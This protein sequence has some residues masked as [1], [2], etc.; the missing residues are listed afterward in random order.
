M[1]EVYR[2]WEGFLEIVSILKALIAADREGDWQAHLQAMENL[3]PVFRECDNI[4]YLR[5]ASWYVEKMGKLPQDHPEIYEKFMQG[6]FVVKQSNREFNAVAPDMKLEQTIQRSKKSVKGIIGQTRQVAYVSQWEIVYHEIIAVS[7]SFRQFINAEVGCRGTV[8]Y[9]MNHELGGNVSGRL[10]SCVKKIYDFIAAG[11]NPYVIRETGSKL[12]HFI[13]GQL[14]TPEYAVRLLS[15]MENGK[16]GFLEFRREVQR[17]V[18]KV[19]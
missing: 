9:I 14:V 17:K 7:N 1:S 2:Y 8:M 13:T 3:L 19:V 10:S 11:G 6:H 18:K 5:Y 16:S 15:F 12:H 4:N